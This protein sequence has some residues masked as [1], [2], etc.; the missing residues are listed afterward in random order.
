M[1]QGEELD[2]ERIKN[3][4]KELDGRGFRQGEE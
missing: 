3:I 4:E 2:M 1:K